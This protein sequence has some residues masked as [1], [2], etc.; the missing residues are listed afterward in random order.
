M[1]PTLAEQLEASVQIQS[2]RR[3]E[4]NGSGP[5][6]PPSEQEPPASVNKGNITDQGEP[7]PLRHS[8]PD[9][10][11]DRPRRRR[12]GLTAITEP[13]HP[14]QP[15][16]LPAELVAKLKEPLPPEAVKP[17]PTKP[18]LSTIKAIYVIE[19]LND[20]FGLGGWNVTNEVIEQGDQM[21]VIK[22]TLTVP[23]YG[24]V[25]E[26][27]G[28]NDNP[29]R[30]DAYKGACTDALTKI[31]AALYIGMDVYKGLTNGRSQPKPATGGTHGAASTTQKPIHTPAQTVVVEKK[32]SD[33]KLTKPWKTF[34]EMKACFA[35]VREQ[36][37]E[38]EY[39][40]ILNSFGKSQATEFKKP[41]EA[42][43]CYAQMAAL[44]GKVA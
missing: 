27:F 8:V 32:L 21:V 44:A 2:A 15:E 25:A 11:P 31:G 5:A 1:T 35:T 19:R 4:A 16:P 37:G 10:G 23:R 26:A 38:V 3:V 28:G 36:L 30:G 17:H 41:V 29:D 33:L 9:A 24:I 20:V 12:S 42:E 40:R 7:T 13:V 39:L 34:G 22:A 6:P 43:A 14:A 18:Y